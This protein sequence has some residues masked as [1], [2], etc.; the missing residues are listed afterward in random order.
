MT[1]QSTIRQKKTEKNKSKMIATVIIP[2]Q[3]VG[4]L[5]H[6]HNWVVIS[7]SHINPETTKVF[8]FFSHLLFWP[9]RGIGWLAMMEEENR[10]RNLRFPDV[11]AA[12]VQ[13]LL[14]VFGIP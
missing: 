11:E 9:V 3:S 2:Y 14:D 5:Q 8:I 13:G 6:Q 12:G 4:L 10:H 1:Y 7:S